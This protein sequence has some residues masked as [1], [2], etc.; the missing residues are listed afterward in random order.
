LARARLRNTPRRIADEEDVA[1]SAFD[2][3][4]R[5]ARAGRFPRL[6]DRHDL[7]QILVLIAFGLRREHFLVELIAAWEPG[8][9]DDGARH[10]RRAQDLSRALAPTALPGGYPNL[11]GPDDHDQIALA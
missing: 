6:D 3:F 5:A 1:P 10:R 9:E 2:S 11:L 8:A 4:C 7:W